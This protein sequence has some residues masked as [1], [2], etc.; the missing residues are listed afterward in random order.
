MSPRR[1]AL[2]TLLSLIAARGWAGSTDLPAPWLP[3][4]PG[5]AHHDRDAADGATA[6]RNAA[7][8]FRFTTRDGGL[9]PVA[10]DNELTHAR[11]P[12]KGEL[13]T[14]TLRDKRRIAASEFRIERDVECRMFPGHADAVRAAE[15]RNG[16]TCVVELR[17]AASGLDVTWSATLRDGSNYVREELHLASGKDLDVAQVALLDIEL[18][19]AWT[20]GTTPGSPVIA[21]DRFFGFEHPM[22]ETRIAGTN[23][24]QFARRKLP[25]RAGVAADYSAVFGVAPKGQLRRAFMAYLENERAAPF[26]TFLHYNS[27]YDIGY[28]TPYTEQEAVDVIDAY[29]RKLV[30]ARGVRMDSFLFDDGWDDHQHLWQFNEHFPHGFAR[31]RAA[32]RRAGAAPGVWLSPWGGYGPPRQ[33][34][35]AAARAAGLEVDDQGLA[36]SGP[37]Y[38]ALFHDATRR[39]LD[40]DGIN[41]FKLDGTGSPDKVTPGS[42]FD[43]D[44]AAAIALIGDLRAVK[45]DLF[46]NLTTG[47]WPSPFWLRTADSIWRGGE[48]HEFAGVGSNRQRWITY[49]DADTYGGI[50]R[51]GPLYPLNS[52]MLHG[53][54]YARNARG[55]NVDPFD[56]F[57]SELR[58]YFAS[59]TGL[60]E[61]YVSPDL[62]T[63]R[64]WD[65][66]AAAATWAR[67]NAATLRDSHWIGGDPARLQ[68]YGWAAWRPGHAIVTLRNPSD[69]LQ[70]FALD[71]GAA[72]ELPPDADR[73]W[74]ARRAW[75]RKAPPRAMRAGQVEA[76][77]L[78]P[79][80]VL[81]LELAPAR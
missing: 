49:R 30:E 47:T 76:I 56:D 41:Q 46:I 77:A 58:S 69:K 11:H 24:L 64:N 1:L 32:A 78:A 37:K 10:I 4:D 61:L 54:V 19:K 15:R 66:L 75:D 5:M 79:F 9:R 48:D 39:L 7:L 18:H 67:A 43:S 72:L 53:I 44:F 59:G 26:R 42:A 62:L 51:L 70:D 2:A 21:D 14:V 29:R 6:L 28:F 20:A 63:E 73:R 38:Y 23:A 35:L 71:V 45:P 22:A 8:A 27:W 40:Q 17:D 13:F 60:Q 81:V 31:V 50:V 55:L 57:A 36:L 68:V 74:T 65:D 12:L 52:L 16:A 34:R 33:E 25:L 80:Q 3:G